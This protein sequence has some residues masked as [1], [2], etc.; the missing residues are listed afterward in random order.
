MMAGGMGLASAAVLG[1]VLSGA[2]NKR[3]RAQS[4][5]AQPVA[6]VESAA[7]APATATKPTPPVGGTASGG[8]PKA[9]ARATGPVRIA[10]LRFR[11]LGSLPEQID[12]GQGLAEAI[13]E[14][15]NGL[16][17][18]VRLVERNQFEEFNLTEL[19]LN[20]EGYMDKDS[21]AKWGRVLGTELLVQ[22]AFQ[23]IDKTLRI[24]AR[25]SRTD[26]D[27]I[28]DSIVL[29]EPFVSAGDV[30]TIHDHVAVAVRD[31]VVKL[32]PQ[33]RP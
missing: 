13:P 4:E 22:G 9:A 20:Q 26:S 25:I 31:H 7:G 21:A 5:G 11:N 14:A 10:V 3:R 33:L 15:F 12:P 2:A 6:T 8:A 1:L 18:R 16:R 17:D 27:E 24:T 19:K 30:F 28:L 23:R 32:L 29:T